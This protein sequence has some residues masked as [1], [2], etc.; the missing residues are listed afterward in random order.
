[1]N[2]ARNTRLSARTGKRKSGL[3]LGEGLALTV[4]HIDAQRKRVLPTASVVDCRVV[5]NGRQTLLYLG[6]HLYRGV[7][8]ERD[9]LGCD[10]AGHVTFR[11]RDAKT[12]KMAV[13][14][15]PSADF[16][17]LVLQHGLPKGLR[18]ARNFGFPHPNSAG[19]VRL[20]QVLH[21]RT[22]RPASAA[23]HTPTMP[24][25]PA[26]RCACGEPMQV[27]RRRMP[28]MPQETPPPTPQPVPPVRATP[29]D[30]HDAARGPSTH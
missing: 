23:I 20:L 1:M 14:T 8:Q 15:L 22:A 21:L 13:R 17:W 11:Y 24:T 30:K 12:D 25:R 5:S 7:A 2:F 3:R 9:I 19:A 10:E 4:A 29:P 6:R 18:R 26:W 16:L 27:I 28:A